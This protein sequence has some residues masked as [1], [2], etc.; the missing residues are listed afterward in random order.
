MVDLSSSLCGSLPG[1]VN[2]HFL[3]VFPAINLHFPMV[4]LWFSHGFRMVFQRFPRHSLK[5]AILFA[6]LPVM[7]PGP[8]W[9]PWTHERRAGRA[10]RAGRADGHVPGL[11]VP[12]GHWS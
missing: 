4:F 5:I 10:G 2:I 1:R 12:M 8:P 3:W 6:N 7:T 11:H 9:T